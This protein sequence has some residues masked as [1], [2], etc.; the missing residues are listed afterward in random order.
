MVSDLLM[1]MLMIKKR[2]HIK[3][4]Y[5]LLYVS[6]THKCKQYFFIFEGVIVLNV[7]AAADSCVD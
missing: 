1:L 7:A 2:S 3:I 6:S 5:V 4:K